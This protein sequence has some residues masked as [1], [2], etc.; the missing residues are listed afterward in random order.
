MA[1]NKKKPQA[2][3]VDENAQVKKQV[4]KVAKKAT[5]KALK[6]RNVQI[7][8]AVIVVLLVITIVVLYFVKPELFDSILGKK[9]YEP[10]NGT[11]HVID[12]ASVVVD[13]IDVGQAMV[14]ISNSHQARICLLMAEQS[15]ELL[16]DGQI[17]LIYLLPRM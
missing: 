7:A 16:Q 6:N 8:L 14:S 2:K 9:T 3:K 1:D 15:S 12:G 5:K 4:K 11:G 10:V 17:L 13:V